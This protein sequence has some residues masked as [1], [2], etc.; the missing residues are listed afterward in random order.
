[1]EGVERTNAMV[2]RGQGQG[3]EVPRRDPY[4]MEVDRE[5]NCYTY[6]G[7]GHI[8]QH[9]RNREQKGRV[10][11]GKRLEYGEK[12]EGNYEHSDNLKEVENLEPLD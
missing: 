2:V 6:G 3:M 7:F 9:Y 10:V 12:K 11:E 5:R 4:A 1:M 8:A